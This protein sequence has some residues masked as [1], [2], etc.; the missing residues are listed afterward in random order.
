MRGLFDKVFK[1][2]NE[3]LAFQQQAARNV[4]MAK[5]AEKDKVAVAQI[6]RLQQLTPTAPPA[7]APVIN[8]TGRVVARAVTSNYTPYVLAGGVLLG[9]VI[10]LRRSR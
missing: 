7:S 3:E 1:S 6:A 9:L 10:W 2:Y 8:A 5:D 4:A